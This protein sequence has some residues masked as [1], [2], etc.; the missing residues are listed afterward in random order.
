M[1]KHPYITAVGLRVSLKPRPHVRWAELRN[2]LGQWR[3]GFARR[4]SLVDLPDRGPDADLVESVLAR[5][6]KDNPKTWPPY[7]HP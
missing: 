2:K 5:M 6:A 7:W 1:A 3:Y 4:V